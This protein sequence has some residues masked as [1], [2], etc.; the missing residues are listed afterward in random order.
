VLDGYLDEP[1]G[2]AI[3]PDGV[4]VADTWNQRVQVFDRNGVFLRQWPITGW[5][6]GLPEEKPYL[7]VDAKGYVYV[8][9]PGH[10]RVLVFDP[11]G[12]YVLSFGQYGFDDR[13]FGL[14]IGIAVAEDSTIYVT[15]AP[16]NRVLVFD[17]LGME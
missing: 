14:P 4:Y 15:D 2:I 16:G 10:Y 3:G 13:S 7:A 1:V 17:P 12:N 11:L 8:T 9:D 6:A 5:D